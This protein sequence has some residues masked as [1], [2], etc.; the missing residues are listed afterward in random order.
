ML[1]SPIFSYVRLRARSVIAAAVCH[2]SLNGTVGLAVIVI[3]GGNDL[4]IGV[5]GLAGFMV[6][7]L[8]NL[9]IYVFERVKNPEGL[10]FLVKQGVNH[11]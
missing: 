11:V 3:R 10:S 6:L 4:T 2:G 5:T 9:G 8:V 7:V 1:L